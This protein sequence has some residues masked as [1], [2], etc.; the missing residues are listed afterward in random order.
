M[1]V[2]PLLLLA[3]L[4]LSACVDTTGENRFE[5]TFNSPVPSIDNPN[6]AI[7]PIDD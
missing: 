2:L 3:A 1:K 7:K 5:A 6:P 4:A